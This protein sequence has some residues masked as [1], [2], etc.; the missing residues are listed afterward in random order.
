MIKTKT[1]KPKLT[2]QTL[3]MRIVKSLKGLKF[4]F[5]SG[6]GWYSYHDKTGW[7][8]VVD[9]TVEA[10][11]NK[12]YR[13]IVQNSENLSAQKLNNV[14]RWVKTYLTVPDVEKECLDPA[15]WIRLDEKEIVAESA[16]GWIACNN[17]LLNV[18]KVAS[19]LYRGEP[20]P[21]EAVKPLTPEL[22]VLGRVPCDFKPGSACPRWEKFINEVCSSNDDRCNL[23]RLFGLSLTYNRKFNVFFVLYGVAGTGK[24]TCLSVLEKL[25]SGAI[26][27]VALSDFGGRFNAF[28]L[29]ENRL[30][31]VADM[32]SVW[33][34]DLKAFEREAVLKSLTGGEIYSVEK[35]GKDAVTRRLVA[36]SVFGSNTVPRF[37]DRSGAIRQRLRLLPFPFQF[38]GKPGQN[39]NLKKELLSELPGVFVWALTGYGELITKGYSTFPESSN[40]EELKHE[41]ELASN[42]V[43]AFCEECLEKAAPD[44]ALSSDAVYK[45]YQSY[46]FGNGLTAAGSNI[47]LPEIASIMGIKKPIPYSKSRRK[48]FLGIRFVIDSEEA[49]TAIP[50]QAVNEVKG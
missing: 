11:I 41:A 46:C 25:N 16:A 20:I 49:K 6:G 29:T 43:L 28:P 8:S 34:T 12:A 15:L 3:A 13:N 1:S 5:V 7:E 23:Q 2:V 47:V 27:S 32:P 14:F 44:F 17:V 36:L 45:K 37:D 31:L 35:K 30:N 42:P 38:R 24:S 48:A 40:A 4:V 21:A 33:D 19:A 9:W 22:F 26:C 10:E 39:P 50:A 18:D